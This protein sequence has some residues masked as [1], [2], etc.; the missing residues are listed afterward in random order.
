MIYT[1]KT[2][3]AMRIAYRAHKSQKDKSG[4]PYIFHPIIVA[5]QMQDEKTTCAALLHDVAEDTDITIDELAGCGFDGDVID[6]LRLLTH[7]LSVPYLEYIERMKDDSIARKV[8][9][10]DLRHN[11]DTARLDVIDDE[12]IE[13]LERYRRAIEILSEEEK[14]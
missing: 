14:I 5:E 6:A 1:D 10:A 12:E 11:S 3:M 8:K 9:L 13:R 2:K 7:D 4:M